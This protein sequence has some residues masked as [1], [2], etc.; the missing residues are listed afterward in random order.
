MAQFSA[1]LRRLRRAAVLLVL[2]L[3]GLLAIAMLAISALV[4]DQVLHP[5]RER[6][7]TTPADL[8]PP[9][10]YEQ[11]HL[12]AS[13]GVRLS[14][15]WIPAEHP[16][17]TVL[18]LH[19]SPHSRLEVLPQ[20]PYLHV[21]GYDLL[22]FDWRAHGESGGD[23][24]SLGF[25]E[26]RDL[27]AALDYASGRG[28]GNVGALAYSMGAATA[29]REQAGDQ[30]LRALVADSTLAT[31]EGAIGTALPILTRGRF[32]GFR[33]GLP[34]FPFGPLAARIAEVRTGLHVA[35]LRAIDQV[36]AFSPRPLLLIYGTADEFVPPEESRRLFAAAR[37]PKELLAVAGAGHPSS[38]KEAFVV[39]PETYQQ[40]VL[41]FFSESLRR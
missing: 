14:G 10:P 3:T 11:V 35:D 23:F 36:Q 17:A 38:G 21:A 22:L 39:D 13:D 18:L 41:A 26:T 37:E 20:A 5:G 16:R 9:L 15:W 8:K 27:A 33:Q 6:M 40:R 24:T 30:R 1:R 7:L 32:V 25:Y 4:A 29:I 28:H 12:T 2:A 34:G 31:V 19:G